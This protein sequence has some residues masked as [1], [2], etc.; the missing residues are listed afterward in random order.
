[1]AGTSNTFFSKKF[2]ITRAPRA[3]IL[4]V[5]Y[6][7][8]GDLQKPTSDNWQWIALEEGQR[9]TSET[10]EEREARLIACSRRRPASETG[11]TARD[12]PLSTSWVTQSKRMKSRLT[13]RH[14]SLFCQ[15]LCSSS[16]RGKSQ[17]VRSS[18]PL[19]NNEMHSPASITMYA[20]RLSHT[21]EGISC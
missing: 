14:N 20:K 7:L 5:H 12:T 2:Q 4:H 8:A 16:I 1:M 11:R 18:L 10:A 13:Q 17:L 3:R 6:N 21:H 15:C 9:L 19:S